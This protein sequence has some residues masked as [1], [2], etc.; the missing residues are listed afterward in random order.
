[1]NY[2]YKS[3]LLKGFCEKQHTV[4][5]RVYKSKNFG[6]I[7][8]NIFSSRLIRE[9]VFSTQVNTKNMHLKVHLDLYAGRLVRKNIR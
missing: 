1:M 4:Y 2:I 5:F 7:L 6:Q 3:L 9:S 8:V